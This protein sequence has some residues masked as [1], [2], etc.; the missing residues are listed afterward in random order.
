MGRMKPDVRQETARASLDVVLSQI[1][2]STMK[3][4]KDEVPPHSGLIRL[5]NGNEEQD[6]RG[7]PGRSASWT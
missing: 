4:T 3:M 1:I 7:G 5:G 6:R 2:K